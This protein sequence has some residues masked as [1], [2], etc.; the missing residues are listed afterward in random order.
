[1]AEGFWR[2]DILFANNFIRA[3][4]VRVELN[5]ASDGTVTGTVGD[6]RIRSGALRRKTWYQRKVLAHGD[7]YLAE[8]Q[9][10]GPIVGD[11]PF[12]RRQVTL[13]FV[14]RGT[15]AT[16]GLYPDGWSVMLPNPDARKKEQ[17]VA[18]MRMDR[19]GSPASSSRQP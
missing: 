5:V 3:R 16:P 13:I 15:F 4:E 18:R 6:A 12:V 10:E 14:P 8:C 19:A 17:L 1:V 7:S 9:L 11:E 2:G